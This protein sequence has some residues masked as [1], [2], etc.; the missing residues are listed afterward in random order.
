MGVHVCDLDVAD[1][2]ALS[3]VPD[4][5]FKPLKCSSEAKMVAAKVEL[6]D[7]N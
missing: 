5:H 6:I 7:R 3:A 1:C 4:P 2:V